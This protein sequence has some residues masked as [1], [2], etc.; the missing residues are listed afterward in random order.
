MHDTVRDSGQQCVCTQVALAAQQKTPSSGEQ[1]SIMAD[2]AYQ[3]WLKNKKAE[4]QQRSKE[5][6]I[7]Q[8]W[9]TLQEKQRELEHDRA[10]IS[11]SSWKRRKDMERELKSEQHRELFG[12]ETPVTV[13][14]TP[15]LPGYCSVWLCDEE[16]ADHMLTRVHR[17]TS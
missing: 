13:N 11:F 17:Q 16:L 8:E 1:Q 7:E 15:L 12:R 6:R 14:Q 10:K 2:R 3:Q 5:E 4:E 9:K